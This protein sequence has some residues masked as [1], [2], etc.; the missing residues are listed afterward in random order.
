MNIPGVNLMNLALSVIGTKQVTWRQF[1]A[2]TQNALGNWVVQYKP[3]QI[4]TGSWQSD[5][6]D[7]VKELGYDSSKNYRRFYVSAPVEGV[8]RGASPDLLITDG[9]KYEVV[10]TDDWSVQDGWVAILCVDIGPDT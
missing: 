9:R 3:D 2:R 7:R 5:P 6:T 10:S 8:N 4:L 1:H